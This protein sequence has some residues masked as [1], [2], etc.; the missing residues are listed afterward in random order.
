MANKPIKLLNDKAIGAML[1]AA[2][3]DAL[4]WPNEL[5]GRSTSKRQPLQGSFQE[6]RQWIRK[7]GGR[8][9]PHDEIIEAGEYSDDTQLILCL[10]RSLLRGDKW[11]EHWTR[12]EL[13]FWTLYER[14]GGGATK[15]AAEVW[16]D[17]TTP[18]SE[19]RNPKEIKLYFEAGGNGVAMRILPHILYHAEAENFKP[20]ASSIFLDGITTHGHPRALVGALAYGYA[21]WCSVRR[22][23]FLKYGEITEE[24]LSALEEWSVLPENHGDW[25]SAAHR[26]MPNYQSAWDSTVHEMKQYLLTCKKELA[27]GALTFDDEVL[28][29]LQCFNREISGAGTVAAAAAVFLASRYAADPMNGV[30][31]AA[32]AIGADTDTIASMTGGL[33][34][35]ICGSDWLPAQRTQVQDSKYLMQISQDVC[36]HQMRSSFEQNSKMRSSLRSWLENLTDKTEA[37]EV[38]LPDGRKAIVSTRPEKIGRSGKYKV[39]FRKLTCNDGQTI[40]LSKISKGS[41]HQLSEKPV[42]TMTIEQN[43]QKKERRCGAKIMVNSFEK[44]VWFY[45]DFLGLTI[46]K[47]SQE[48]VVFDQGLVLVPITYTINLPDGL[49]FRSLIYIQATDIKERFSLAEKQN[50]GIIS[51]LSTWGQSGM[52]FFRCLDP[53]GNV[54]EVLGR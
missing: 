54:I 37:S 41:F 12:V 29:Q 25:F 32:F 11:W 33:L 26:Y 18:W 13:P 10:S 30:V 16:I 48:Y 35:T 9:F 28:R 3:G 31:K 44:S 6:F 47:Q 40:Y 52:L 45:R 20:V 23:S 38:V 46:K 17:G 53:D 51:V 39:E 4:G 22:E 36:N 15:R 19:K 8:F 1:G 14:G 34:G 21:L 49:N 27:K 43:S 5:R 2:C 50:I 42:Q 7:S 24:L